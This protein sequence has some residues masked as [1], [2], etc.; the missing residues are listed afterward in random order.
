MRR[1]LNFIYCYGFYFDLIG[2]IDL[3]YFIGFNF[4]FYV[5]KWKS[6]I[7]YAVSFIYYNLSLHWFPFSSF[8][9]KFFLSQMIMAPFHRYHHQQF[10]FPS[11]LLIYLLP[12]SVTTR[13][14][15]CYHR[16]FNPKP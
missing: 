6:N 15:H 10:T 11:N 14:D 2:Y 5:Y 16:Q 1:I 13:S 7:M 4:N 3:F 12:T 8:Q 9:G